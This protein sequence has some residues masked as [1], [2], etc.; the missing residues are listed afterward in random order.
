MK[1]ISSDNVMSRVILY[2]EIENMVKISVD[3]FPSA[4]TRKD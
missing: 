1:K 4:K 3:S 2:V